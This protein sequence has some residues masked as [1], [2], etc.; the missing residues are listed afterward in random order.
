MTTLSVI[1]ALCCLQQDLEVLFTEVITTN[2]S[3]IL[4]TFPSV[5]LLYVADLEQV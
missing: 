4:G 1:P 5:F 3:G 2:I